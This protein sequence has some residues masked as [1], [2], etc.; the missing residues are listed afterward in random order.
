L[1]KDFEIALASPTS[2]G[3]DPIDTATNKI[4]PRGA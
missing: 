3:T 2:D 1:F 4:T